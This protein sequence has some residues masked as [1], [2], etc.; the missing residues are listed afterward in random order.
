MSAATAGFGQQTAAT[1]DGDA[2]LAILALDPEAVAGRC[3]V[4]LGGLL[5]TISA[6]IARL[7]LIAEGES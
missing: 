5:R 3:W 2:A 1:L 6:I 7:A 4:T